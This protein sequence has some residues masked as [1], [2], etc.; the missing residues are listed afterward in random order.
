[1]MPVPSKIWLYRI[2]HISNLKHILQYGLVTFQSPN[3]NRDF[4]QIGD[5]TLIEYRKDL[6]APNPPGGKLSEYIPFYLGPRS[7]MLFQIAT[8]FEGIRQFGQ[9]EIIYLITSLDSIKTHK[10]NYFFTDGHARSLTSSK[11]VD[12]K[13][14]ELL[15]WKTIYDTFWK[16]DNSD[17]RRKEKKQAELLIKNELP[18]SC[19]EHICVF[20]ESA[21]QNVI[22]LLQA[23][24]IEIQVRISPTKLYYD[25][26]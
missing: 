9:Q 2:T 7:P 11:Y 24:N 8:G 3:A 4:V 10:L 19:I 23:A 16:N 25:H 6:D 22:N 20:N 21:R 13:D 26:L 5:N 15:D 17:L 18:L 1:M 14:F 12:D